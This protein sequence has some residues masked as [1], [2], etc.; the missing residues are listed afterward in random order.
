MQTINAEPTQ[1]LNVDLPQSQYFALK[2]YALHANKTVSQLVRESLQEVVNYD[3]W[4]RTRVEAARAEA[5]DPDQPKYTHQDWQSIRNAK[6][7]KAN[8]LAVKAPAT[9]TQRKSKASA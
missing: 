5:A 9:P 8:K 6:L 1:R 7:E 3:T 2:S 4:F